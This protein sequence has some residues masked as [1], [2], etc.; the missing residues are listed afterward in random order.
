MP[1]GIG[2]VEHL[3]AAGGCIRIRKR[4]AEVGA[5]S[6]KG[7]SVKS[8][9]WEMQATRHRV[10]RAAQRNVVC[11]MEAAHRLAGTFQPTS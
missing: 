1:V 2:W 3:V 5:G 9:C 7:R 4:R 10:Y 11:Q 8:S 6:V